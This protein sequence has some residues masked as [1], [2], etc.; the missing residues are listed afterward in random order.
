[1]Y[2]NPYNCE[3]ILPTTVLTFI[4]FFMN[5]CVLIISDKGLL[6]L[7]FHKSGR[8]DVR[9]LNEWNDNFSVFCFTVTFFKIQLDFDILYFVNPMNKKKDPRCSVWESRAKRWGPIWKI[10]SRT[11]KIDLRFLLI[12]EDHK[13]I[14]KTKVFPF[15]RRSCSYDDRPRI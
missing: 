13:F 9:M 1:M 4:K 7:L 14:G 11:P 6:L 8:K 2:L 3:E 10:K 5:C 15:C 12:W